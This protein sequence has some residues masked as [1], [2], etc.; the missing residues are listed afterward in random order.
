[1]VHAE[2]LMEVLSAYADSVTLPQDS[3]NSHF[4]LF[5]FVKQRN[6]QWPATKLDDELEREGIVQRGASLLKPCIYKRR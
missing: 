4:V 6:D 2:R 5:E 1:M 3:S